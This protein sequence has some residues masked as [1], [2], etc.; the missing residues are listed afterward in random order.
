MP[1]PLALAAPLVTVAVALWLIGCGAAGDATVLSGTV[2]LD[3]APLSAGQ[4]RF[5]PVGGQGPTAGGAITD[6]RYSVAVAPGEKKVEISAAKVVGQQ[7]MYEAA[8]SQSVD[9]VGELLPARYNAQ[10]ELRVTAA[11]GSQQ[12]NF[13][14]TSK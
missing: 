7:R 9:V 2:T 1:R 4:I 5:V 11:G 3:G 10:T 12:Q 13:A 14:L 6:G 8:G